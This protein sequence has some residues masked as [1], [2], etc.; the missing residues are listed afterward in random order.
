MEAVNYSDKDNEAWTEKNEQQ[1]T[2]IGEMTVVS[3]KS[4]YFSCK[5]S[6]QEDFMTS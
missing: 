2:L 6:R 4:Q 1:F 5:V 3:V